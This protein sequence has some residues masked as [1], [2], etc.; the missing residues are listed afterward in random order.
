MFRVD[1]AVRQGYK[2]IEMYEVYHWSNTEQYNPETKTG[3]YLKI[4]IFKIKY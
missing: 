2:I 3:N 4:D 1:E